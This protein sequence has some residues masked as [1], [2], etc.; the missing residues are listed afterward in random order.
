MKG[1]KKQ[2][3]GRRSR[4]TRFEN[5]SENADPMKKKHGLKERRTRE[6]EATQAL[7]K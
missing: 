5:L 1:K 3:R 7:G 4:S 6:E 2:N